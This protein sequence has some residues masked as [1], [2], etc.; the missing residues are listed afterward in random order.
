MES[1]MKVMV[2]VLAGVVFILYSIGLKN[3]RQFHNLLLAGSLE[4]EGESIQISQILVQARMLVFF[5]FGVNLGMWLLCFVYLSHILGGIGCACSFID[6]IMNYEVLSRLGRK[7]YGKGTA[8]L[9]M[10]SFY[11]V[12]ILYL[13]CLLAFIYLAINQ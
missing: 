13:G 6:F 10:S 2:L 8:T 1:S 3:R 12:S 9:I 7:P 11:L 5:V 4:V